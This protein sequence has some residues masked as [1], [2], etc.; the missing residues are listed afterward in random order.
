MARVEKIV[1]KMRNRPNGIRFDEIVKV[2]QH[3]GYI[4]VRVKGSHHHFR[5]ERGDLVTEME[6]KNLA[7]YMS[8]SYTIQIQHISDESGRYYYAKVLE[9]D[10]CQSH[11]HTI[12]E[13]YQNIQEAMEGWIES[14]LEWGDPIPEPTAD[15]EYSGKFVLRLP[16]SFH[17]E[18]AEQ[19]RRE[20]ISLNQYILYK[21]SH[22]S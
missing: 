15:E 10:G 9:L 7:Y 16:K 3:Y 21:L 11:G 18:L 20:N 4:Q 6:N 19:A 17:R 1:A 2:L 14:K 12:E 5:N 8:L 22:S 13:A